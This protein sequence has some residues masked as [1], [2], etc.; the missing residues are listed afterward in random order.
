MVR[1]AL[2]ALGFLTRLPV[3][4]LVVDDA[5]FARSAGFFSWVGLF[6]GGLLQALAWA[7]V[8]ALGAPI[9][10]TL[11]AVAL[12]W[13]S[14]GLHL[15]GLADTVDGLSGGRGRRERTLEIMHDSR[16]GAHGAVA[17]VLALVLKAQLLGALCTAPLWI[18]PLVA[19]FA[20]TALLA[21]FPYAR[22]A[23][24]GASFA[25]RV[26]RRELIVGGAAL[27]ALALP[28]ARLGLALAALAGLLFAFL[29]ALRIR[30]FLGGLTGDVHGAVIE[31]TELV[32][33]L[34]LAAQAG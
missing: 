8:P 10:G 26:G 25:G 18:A 7:L 21:A 6:L 15:D 12:A 20:C 16:I 11:L 9:T 30:R 27:F 2:C 1:S 4:T 28:E 19:R 29:F 5:E 34:A 24:L 33:L 32:V 14:G 13:L 31:L 22:S 17:L 3:P 23:G